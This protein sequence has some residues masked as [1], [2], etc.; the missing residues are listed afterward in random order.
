MSFL[1]Y[2]PNLKY[3]DLRMNRI[4]DLSELGHLIHLDTL[5]ISLNRITCLNLNFRN[6]QQV[7]ASYNEVK[8]VELH[9]P[10]LETLCKI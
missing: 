7:D 4:S 1:K 9:T 6:L 2:C 3:L 5:N 10:E 8:R